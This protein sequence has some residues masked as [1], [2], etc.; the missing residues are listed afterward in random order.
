[1]A[2]SGTEPIELNE[3]AVEIYTPLSHNDVKEWSADELE[4]YLDSKISLVE[5]EGTMYIRYRT[6][7][8]KRLPQGLLF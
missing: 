7:I 1:M 2:S 3:T 5:A 8:L 6:K 4:N